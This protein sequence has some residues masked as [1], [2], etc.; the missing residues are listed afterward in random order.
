MTR[1]DGARRSDTAVNIEAFASWVFPLGAATA[2]FFQLHIPSGS[3]HVNVNMADPIAVLMGMMFVVLHYGGVGLRWRLPGIN[4]SIVAATAVVMVSYAHGYLRFG[5]SDWAFTSK[6]LGW[7]VLLGYGATGAV[8]VRAGGREGLRMLLRT[9]VAVACGLVLLQLVLLA[10]KRMGLSIPGLASDLPFTGFSQN[11]NA[12]GFLL[13]LAVCCFPLLGQ[14]RPTWFL[15]ILFLG[16]WFSGSKAIAGATVIV[17][18]TMIAIAALQVRCILSAL[19]VTVAVLLA[20]SIMPWVTS[21]EFG[22]SAL[23]SQLLISSELSN[24]QRLQSMIGGIELFL[25]HP[26]FGAGLGAYME[27]QIKLRDPLI[28]HSTPIWLLAEMGVIGAVVLMLPVTR[29]FFAEARNSTEEVSAFLL[30]IILAFAI[31]CQVHE[32]MFQRAF[33]LLLGAGLACLPTDGDRAARQ[34]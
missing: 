16:V 15:S 8:I 14:R 10:G 2:L 12:F 4:A 33:W 5:W 11:R 30:L 24:A 1:A 20:Y 22:A 9:F 31:V 27:A 17:L 23:D 18:A 26:L 3:G 21:L 7:F 28:I 19:S 25:Q 6:L 32:I 13:L 29:V 34:R